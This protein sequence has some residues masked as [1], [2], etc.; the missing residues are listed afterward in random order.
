MRKGD[1]VRLGKVTFKVL[2][3]QSTKPIGKDGKQGLD[4][5]VD[6]EHNKSR[7]ISDKDLDEDEVHN[8]DVIG[9]DAIEGDN[10]I[11]NNNDQ[12]KAF[13]RV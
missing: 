2:D 13:D 11:N 8:N 9:S 3:L 7:T 4:G 12:F 10:N 5:I 1:I 6:E